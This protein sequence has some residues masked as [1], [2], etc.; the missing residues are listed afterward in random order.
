MREILDDFRPK[1]KLSKD[2]S[3]KDQL[4]ADKVNWKERVPNDVRNDKYKE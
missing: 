3:L 4:E 2:T 1:L